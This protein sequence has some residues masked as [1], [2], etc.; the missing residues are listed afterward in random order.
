MPDLHSLLKPPYIFL[1]VGVMWFFGA[2]VST[3]TGKTWGRVGY[4]ISPAEEPSKFWGVVAMY[5]LGGVLF[6]GYFLY[7]AG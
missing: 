6:I 2:I 1:I 7:L 3:C 4:T 5:Y